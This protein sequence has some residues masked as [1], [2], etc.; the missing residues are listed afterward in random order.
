M[1]E[2]IVSLNRHSMLN[3]WSRFETFEISDLQCNRKQHKLAVHNLA[4]SGL[5]YDNGNRIMIC[6]Y[7]LD[8]VAD[9]NIQIILDRMNVVMELNGEIMAYIFSAH[10]ILNC[11]MERKYCWNYQYQD[12]PKGAPEQ[13]PSWYDLK[14]KNILFNSNQLRWK[15]VLTEGDIGTG[16]GNA[17]YLKPF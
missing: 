15:T 2:P 5:C 7:C 6:V 3:P 12:C 17:F 1:K 8:F 13:Y 16:L 11:V 14:K 9:P 10:D 4:R